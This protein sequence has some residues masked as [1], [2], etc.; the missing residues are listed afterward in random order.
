M[1]M[2][3]PLYTRDILRLAADSAQL[4]RL[5]PADGSGEARSPVCGSRMQADVRLDDDGRVV[6]FGGSV[7]ACAMGQASAILFARHVAGR[8]ASEVAAERDALRDY[9][10]GMT[11][12]PTWPDLA[13]FAAARSRPARHAAILLPF[14]ATLAAMAAAR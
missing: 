6:A 12:R 2:A 7:N 1:T 9:L 3:E 8:T 11:E 10:G 4:A 14:D 5:N 13:V